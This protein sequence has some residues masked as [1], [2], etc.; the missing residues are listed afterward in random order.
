MFDQDM[1]ANIKVGRILTEGQGQFIDGKQY[2][3]VV[4]AQDVSISPPQR[5]LATVEV[6]VGVRPPQFY[7]ENYHGYV[8]ENNGIGQT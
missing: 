3:L 7:Q 6:R 4:V 1:R 8:F 5:T 2:D